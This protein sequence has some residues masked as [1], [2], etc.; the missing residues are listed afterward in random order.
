[1]KSEKKRIQKSR[2]RSSITFFI[3]PDRRKKIQALADAEGASLS[4][5][6][7]W[8][9]VKGLKTWTGRNDW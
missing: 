2:I 6:I 1:M 9:I 7:R 3:E 4:L 8:L 5:M